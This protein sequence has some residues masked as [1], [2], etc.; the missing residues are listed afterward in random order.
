M[1]LAAEAVAASSGSFTV[2]PRWATPRTPERPSFGPVVGRISAAMGR[3]FMPHQQMVVDVALE[4]QSEAAGDPN[5]GD[6]AYDDPGFTGPRRL[7][8]TSII[9]PVTV[10]R[11]ETI[12]RA[13]ILMTAQKD[14]KA[15]DRWMDA[16]EDILGSELR[17]TVR[18][19]VSHSFEEMRWIKTGSTFGPFAPKEDETH[20]DTLHL[21]WVDEVWAFSQEQ[22][23]RVQAGYVPAFATTN[24][25]AW[26]MSTQ[27]TSKSEWLA[28]LTKAGR[29]AVE[30]GVRLGTAWFEWSLP[31]APYGIPIE[32][33]TDDQLVQACIDWH[34]A[35]CHVP[36]CSGPSG[37]RP[38]VHGF[39]VRPAAIR[40]AW[41][42]MEFDRS[43][44]LRAYGN[45]SQDDLSKSWSVVSESTW[46]GQNDDV[47][48]PAD[49]PVSLGIGV[50]PDSGD[51][52]VSAGW[53]DPSGRMHVELLPEGHRLGT[54]WVA[55]YVAG[56]D[57]R[58]RLAA[59]AVANTG[60]S[61]EIADA[62]APLL[63]DRLL[64]V[65]AADLSAACVR[66]QDELAARTWWHMHSPAVHE[67]VKDA[68]VDVRRVWVKDS[69]PVSA[70]MSQTLAGWAHDH[71]PVPEPET[72]FWMG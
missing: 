45:R 9:T 24:G 38:C 7:G 25:Q 63:G 28:A 64:R 12:R 4:V 65:S 36:G 37:G 66:H 57:E 70:V 17:D 41:V 62:L 27:G 15:R 72:D 3:P 29:K 32:K 18:R 43:E 14:S 16:T 33:L 68:A 61:R 60:T 39:T 20:G 22:R 51:A 35:V 50:D 30:S 6:W 53:R 44:M 26:K 49:A 40:S 42:Q 56:L 34:P 48:I 19:K 8:K 67:A 54:R 55:S 31:D 1:T 46:L 58:N 13:V 59:V 5:P 52:G 69:T 71:A 47:R 10:H 2:A 21:V 11:A 23:R